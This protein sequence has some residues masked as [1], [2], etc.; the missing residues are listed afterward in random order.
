M[1]EE[2]DVLRD[3]A[4]YANEN[5]HSKTSVLLN[6]FYELERAKS[7]DIRDLEVGTNFE[8]VD[9]KDESEKGGVIVL[10]KTENSDEKRWYS[11]ERHTVFIFGKNKRPVKIVG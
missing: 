3:I 7:Y 10:V 11:P 5:I 9:T 2:I 4:K 8:F 6:L 1:R